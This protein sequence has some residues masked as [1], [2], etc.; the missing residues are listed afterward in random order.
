MADKIGGAA[1]EE[2]IGTDLA[3]LL[4]GAGGNDTMRGGKGDDVYRVNSAEDVIVEASGQ[5]TDT[6]ESLV[7]FT[8]A[9]NVENLTLLSAA[10]AGTGNSGNNKL[11]GNA[12]AN[13]LSGDAGN[14]TL[15]GAGGADT[16]IG[17]AGNDTYI[18]DDAN[19]NLTESLKA[20]TDRVISSVDFTLGANIE[21]LALQQ[22]AGDRK[23]TGN[24]LNNKLFGNEGNNF[25][26]GAGGKDTMIGGAGN[27]VYVV[28][29]KDDLVT[30]LAGEGTDEIRA[31]IS[32]VLG[33][34]LENLT[35]TGAGNIDGI[36]NLLDNRIVG[37]IGNNKIDGGIGADKLEG[38]AGNDSYVVD[39]VADIVVELAG[40]GLD[41]VTSSV[42]FA[43]SDNVE[44][45]LLTGKSNL[46]ARGSAQAN[47]IVGNTG[48]NRIED[49]ANG[50]NDKFD[51]G[52]GND[53]LLGND[54]DDTLIGGAGNDSLEG[55]LGKDTLDGGAG[56]DIYVV[57]D[58]ADI[59]V[60][61]SNGGI[62]EIRS[63]VSLTL[64]ANIE[65]L[66][67]LGTAFGGTGNTL[68][69]LIVGNG[70]A[71][72]LTGAAGNDTLV[73]G[74][75]GTDTLAGGTGNDVYVVAGS[76]ILD[77]KNGE[78]IDRVETSVNFALAAGV[79]IEVIV[80]TGPNQVNISG[81]EIDNKIIGNAGVNN[82]AGG[83]G[84]DTID[85]GAGIDRIDGND[86]N[87]SLIGGE[88]SDILD[89]G[90]GDDI[91]AGGVGDD[92]YTVDSK[93]DK[94]TEAANGGIDT[95]IA[96]F[97]FT[98][99]T[100]FENLSLFNGGTRGTGNSA[101]NLIDGNAG[102]NILF[103]LDGNDTISGF[104]GNDTL[105]GGKG[106]DTL[107]GGNGN[108]VFIVDNVGDV[109]LDSAGLDRI[110]ALVSVDLL[111]SNTIENV[112]LLGA[113]A[114]SASGNNIDNSL[115]GNTGNNSLVGLFGND[116]LRGGAGNDTLVG[117]DG[118]D[119]LEGGIGTDLLAGGVGNDIYLVSSSADLLDKI[120]EKANEG[121][122]RVDSL[123]SFSLASIENV[124]NLF[125]GGGNLNGT[126]NLLDNLLRGTIGNNLLIGGAGNDTFDGVA[127]SDTFEGGDGVDV[128]SYAAADDRVVVDLTSGSDDNLIEGNLGEAAGDVLASIEG[129]EG[130]RFNDT[131]RGDAA[132]NFLLGGDG[133]DRFLSSLGLD[134][135]DGGA[136]DDRYELGTDKN[137]EAVTLREAAGGGFDTLLVGVN[138]SL[139]A[140]VEIEAIRLVG[141]NN[142]VTVTGNEFGNDIADGTGF[143]SILVGG[144][145]DDTLLGGAGKDTLDGGEGNDRLIGTFDGSLMIGGNGDDI[146]ESVGIG[147]I[148]ETADG[149]TDTIVVNA[150]EGVLDL[151]AFSNVENAIVTGGGDGPMTVIGNDADNRLEG[152]GSKDVL[153]GGAGSDTLVGS[154]G[155]DLLSGGAGDDT[156]IVTSAGVTLIEQTG[157]GR[158]TVVSAISFTLGAQF[159]NLTL[160]GIEGIEGTGNALANV[161]AGNAG[162]NALQG[163]DGNDTLIGGGGA[164]VLDGGTGI[165][166]ADYGASLVGVKINLQQGS[167]Q[168]GDAAGDTLIGIENLLGSSLADDLDGDFN[169][170]ALIGLAGNDSLSGGVGNDTL[171]GGSGNDLMQGGDGSDVIVWRFETD[172]RDTV[173][174]GSGIDTLQL[175]TD[176]FSPNTI[177]FSNLDNNVVTSQVGLFKGIEVLDQTDGHARTTVLSSADVI[178]LQGDVNIQIVAEFVDLMFLGD[179]NDKLTLDGNWVANGSI[180]GFNIFTDGVS[181]LAVESGLAV[182][183]I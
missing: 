58:P 125:L 8:L 13:K 83:A 87:D 18:V 75:G 157:E 175:G 119:S 110:E 100:G 102:G 70:L 25:F 31:S 176:G 123:I 93:L 132:D 143:S 89:G 129:I 6:A 20:G 166:T 103:G 81:N 179:T 72:Q 134:T 135:L 172:L 38:G 115:I 170:N 11:V 65:N 66:T 61:L 151:R 48:N 147:A 117:G 7:D 36:G 28:D 56:N 141:K 64:A 19:D 173:E 167:V 43:L 52:A 178:G 101:S 68:N 17:G 116:T 106:A 146:Y 150:A 60:E 62:D 177:N 5:G 120:D 53:T 33:A 12:N 148:I 32:L 26:D 96:G 15:D 74:G 55:G 91:M 169:A 155:T 133:N 23:A 156:Y 14:D 130:T 57:D 168:F 71:N 162:A 163:L 161:I 97:D 77:E 139:A 42:D 76:A 4:D 144:A 158:D 39:N 78:G 47:V 9:A 136:G 183:I 16:L 59:I 54:G 159:E 98:L 154:G 86:G 152:N 142:N 21:E 171:S 92:T 51:G 160:S 113:G 107:N 3:D 114:L 27:D 122:D 84:K 46:N 108:D 30:E 112:T 118:A 104:D 49:V 80:A 94:I 63:S 137:P 10:I 149:G 95:V 37:N 24:T 126:G 73:G 29:S 121:I 182:N 131:L 35:L 82:L 180:Q 174:G 41:R 127:G 138:F 34:T 105:D 153:I 111:L 45:L 88:G 165:D 85:G 67:L 128:V 1:S 145:G 2:L 40:E 90:A 181:K 79:S 124:E 140:G 44:E 22:G 50:G 164:D 69:N 99:A 109:V